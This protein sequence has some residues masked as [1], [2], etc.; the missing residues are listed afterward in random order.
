MRGIDLNL[1]FHLSVYGMKKYYYNKIYVRAEYNV[2]TVRS[3]T[4]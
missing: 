1:Q 2:L 4:E 3:F